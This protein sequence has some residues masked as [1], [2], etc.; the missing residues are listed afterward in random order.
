LSK[1]IGNFEFPDPFIFLAKYSQSVDSALTETVKFLHAQS[2]LQPVLGMILG[3]GLGSYTDHFADRTILPYT[4]LPHFPRS[5]EPGH[6]GNLVIGSVEGIACIALQGR[7]HYYEG[8]AMQDIAFPVRVLSSLGIQKLIVTNASGGLNPDFEPGDLM[9]IED[10]IN[11]MGSNPLIG[12]TP[13]EPEQRFADM[14]RAYDPDM[15]EIAV[16]VA[17]RKKIVL[18]RGI[19]VGVS[20]P[21]Y[22]TP[23]EIRMFRSFGADAIGMSTVPEVIAAVKA[24]IRVLGISCIANKAAGIGAERITH[25]EVLETTKNAE[26]K[27][28]DLL[29]GII[30][31]VKCQMSK[32]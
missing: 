19:Y 22:E 3:T 27:F 24:G 31:T 1:W 2:R 18:H 12:H 14:S 25:H 8:Y 26:A 10:H 13:H 6:P 21:C 5:S 17:R 23:A 4:I 7:F 20:G 16:D 15:L 28:S 29:N 11:M 32:V 9:L 30:K